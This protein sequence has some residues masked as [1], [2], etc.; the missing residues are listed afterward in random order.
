[1]I[2]SVLLSLCFAL[3]AI[4][5]NPPGYDTAFRAAK[6]RG[7]PLVIF[8]GC[9]GRTLADAQCMECMRAPSLGANE[10]VIIVGDVF[11]LKC[12]R[13]PITA[14][15]AEIRAVYPPRFKPQYREMQSGG[16]VYRE[17]YSAP[18]VYTK[19]PASTPAVSPPPPIVPQTLPI[20]SYGG[21]V[22]GGYQIGPIGGY[23][24]FGGYGSAPCVGGA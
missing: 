24:G 17:Y 18:P 11:T 22:Y 13:L 15:D 16:K 21:A 10:P 6:E 1:M 23:G 8:V 9:E 5:Q 4:A 14:T 20:L 2:R 7:V 19:T 12:H 3:P